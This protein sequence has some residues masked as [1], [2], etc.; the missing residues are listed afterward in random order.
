ML[1]FWNIH[2]QKYIDVQLVPCDMRRKGGEG[3]ANWGH[4]IEGVLE[5]GGGMQ[6]RWRQYP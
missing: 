1:R 3:E 2:M 5:G 6:C 4:N